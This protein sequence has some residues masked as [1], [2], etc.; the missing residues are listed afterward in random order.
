MKKR[1]VHVVGARPNFMKL[2]PVYESVSKY[3]D[4]EQILIHTGQHYDHNMSDVFFKEFQLPVPNENLNIHGGTNLEQIGNGIIAMEKI[5]LKYNPDLLCVYGDINATVYSSIVASKLGIKIAH[6]EAGL[7]S[8]DRTMPEETNRIITDVLTDYYFTPSIDADEHLINEGID[9]EK[10]YFV[11]NVMIDTLI[12][13]LPKAKKS[14]FQFEIPKK[15]CLVTLH[16]PS[17]VDNEKQ[18]KEILVYLQSLG[19][20]YKIIFPLHPRTRQKLALNFLNSLTNILFIEPV[21]YLQFLKLQQEASFIITDSGGI[22]E[23]STFLGVPCF[24]LRENTERPIT[25]TEGTNTL[26]GAEISALDFHL[27]EFK[28]GNIKKGR[29]PVFWDGKASIRIAKIINTI[30]SGEKE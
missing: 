11:G 12:K 29:I 8:S 5:L 21:G 2:A 1:I 10:I 3:N 23:E 7:R 15:Y 16:R 27:T 14:I 4:I 28:K 17:N 26:V 18:L 19:E 24:T 6:I 9:K 25:I 20:E 30:V 22:Q 13:F